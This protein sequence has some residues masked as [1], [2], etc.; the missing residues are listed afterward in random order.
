VRGVD[1]Q[2]VESMKA[3]L[4]KAG[5]FITDTDKVKDMISGIDRRPELGLYLAKKLDAQN[6]KTIHQNNNQPSR[7]KLRAC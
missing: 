6:K 2:G 1:L 3:K 7:K 5:G 4:L